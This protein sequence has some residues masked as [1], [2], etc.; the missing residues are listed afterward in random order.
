MNTDV[1]KGKWTQIKGEARSQW[2][3]LTDDEVDQIAGDRDKL[4]GKIQEK[5]GIARNEA[6]AQV[7]DWLSKI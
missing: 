7:N 2:G 1:I 6:E 5:Y 3:K 4:I